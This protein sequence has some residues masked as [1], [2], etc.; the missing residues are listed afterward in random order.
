MI[1]LHSHLLPCIDDGASS[2]ADSLQLARM[3]VA[4]GITHI[5]LTPHIH[6]GRFDNDISTITPAFSS[7]RQAVEAANIPLTLA[8]AG[9]VRISDELLMLVPQKKVPFLGEWQGKKVL[10]LEL[11]HSHIPPGTEKLVKWLL[12]QNIVPMIAHPER[13]KD[14][15]RNIDLILPF[16]EMGCLFQVTAMSMSGDFGKESEQRSIQLLEKGWITILATDAHNMKHRPPV[17]SKGYE[18]AKQIVGEATAKALVLDTPR[19]IAGL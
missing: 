12:A 19:L 15:L 10:L 9:E 2:L 18:A 3:A 17:L 1:D 16:V 14:I 11:P 5:T 4:D 6:T 7:F 13:N 8:I